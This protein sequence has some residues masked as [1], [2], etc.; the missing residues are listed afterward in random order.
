MPATTVGNRAER[1]PCC[2]LLIGVGMLSPRRDD[3]YLVEDLVGGNRG[4][5]QIG[6][7]VGCRHDLEL[8]STDDAFAA[9]RKHDGSFAHPSVTATCGMTCCVPCLCAGEQAGLH[10]SMQ[11]LQTTARHGRP[12][13]LCGLRALQQRQPEGRGG[14]GA[15]AHTAGGVGVCFRLRGMS[16]R[17]V[18]PWLTGMLGL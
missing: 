11:P 6:G 2:L 15:A 8:V 3:Q 10:A 4:V 1:R 16:P 17:L 7:T 9:L 18:L 13:P 14:G 5:F 12:T